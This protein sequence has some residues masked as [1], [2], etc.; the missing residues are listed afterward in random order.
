LSNSQCVVEW[1]TT[2]GHTRIIVVTTSLSEYRKTQTATQTEGQTDRQTDRQTAVHYPSDVRD[3]NS[4]INK[5][6]QTH[7]HTHT[8]TD[9][10]TDR[11]TVVQTC[12]RRDSL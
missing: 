8:Q 10:Q 1:Q 4:V 12:F 6:Q 9:R 3:N 5:L 11:Q 2:T 7:T